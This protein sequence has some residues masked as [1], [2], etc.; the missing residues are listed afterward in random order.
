MDNYLGEIRIFAGN[1]APEDWA[2]C[3]G[4][5]LPISQYQAL[6]SLIGTAFGGDGVSTFGVPNLQGAL[7]IGQGQGTGLT[8]YPRASSGGVA[9]V[10]LTSDNVPPHTHQMMAYTGPATSATPSGLL[11]AAA[12]AGTTA[13]LP[14]TSANVTRRLLDSNALSWTGWSGGAHSNLMP[15]LCLSYIIALV[16]DYPTFN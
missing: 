8:N 7:A 1:Y 9:T 11:Y 15:S 14:S 2:F 6:Y 3:N 4:Q 5:L 10:T 12:P 13:Y 16:G